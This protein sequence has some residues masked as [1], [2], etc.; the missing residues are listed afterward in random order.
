M[1]RLFGHISPHFTFNTLNNI[2]ALILINPELVRE[3]ITRFA[4]TLRYQFTGG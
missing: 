3:Q 2:R 4:S 1:Q